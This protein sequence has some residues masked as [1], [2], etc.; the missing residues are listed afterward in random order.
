MENPVLIISATLAY[1]NVNHF[2][3]WGWKEE[4]KCGII[5]TV[6]KY[7]SQDPVEGKHITSP[8]PLCTLQVTFL[9]TGARAQC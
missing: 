5:S 4:P 3:Q 8:A 1:F 2:C 6:R 7:F 9:S